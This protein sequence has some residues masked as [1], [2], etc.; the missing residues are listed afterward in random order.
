MLLAVRTTLDL[1]ADVL[2]AAKEMASVHG[3]DGR[4][5]DFRSRAQGSRACLCHHQDAQWG[6]V[7]AAPRPPGRRPSDHASS[8]TDLLDEACESRR[9]A[10][11][12]RPCRALRARPR[13]PRRSP[14]TGSPSN[15]QAGWATC[16][17]TETGLVRVLLASPRVP[18][19]RHRR[20]SR[21]RATA[22][23]S[24][25]AWPAHEW[26]AA[27]TSRSTDASAVPVDVDART[28]AGDGRLPRRPRPFAR[29][30]AGRRSI[31]AVPV[32]RDRR[33]Q[34]L[35]SSQVIDPQH[36]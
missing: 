28:S 15:R 33:R 4:Q 26:W 10:G 2:Q 21:R 30:K 7:D 12:Q 19:G 20:I 25:S 1:D 31:A 9:P 32:E 14:T 17:L 34:A 16:P 22:P 6:P 24:K 18:H 36:S 27:M 11:R 8:S 13:A 3:H 23:A 5:G 35:D 29:W